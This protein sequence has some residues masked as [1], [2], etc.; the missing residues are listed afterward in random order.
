MQ[1]SHAAPDPELS[2]QGFEVHKN[3]NQEWYIHAEYIHSSAQL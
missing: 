1:G 2:R 3:K